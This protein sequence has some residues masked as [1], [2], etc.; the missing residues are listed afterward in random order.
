MPITFTFALSQQQTF[1]LRCDYGSRRLDEA[2]LLALIDQCEQNYYSK[3][4]DRH[5]RRYRK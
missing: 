5:Y 4:S 1:E 3:E 2:E